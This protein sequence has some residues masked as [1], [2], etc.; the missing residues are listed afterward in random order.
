MFAA[1]RTYIRAQ[2]DWRV[3][4]VLW[5][6]YGVSASVAWAINQLSRLVLYAAGSG[7]R[8]T[9]QGSATAIMAKVT[10]LLFVLGAAAAYVGAPSLAGSLFSLAMFPI[11]MLGA[12]IVFRG[13]FRS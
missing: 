7:V 10:A 2:H 13:V 1:S 9:F 6:L 8:S 3:R 12:I 5:C 4:I 11:M